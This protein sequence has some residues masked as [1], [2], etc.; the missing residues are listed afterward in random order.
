MLSLSSQGKQVVNYAGLLLAYVTPIFLFCLIL[1]ANSFMRYYHPQ[2]AAFAN[3]FAWV[4]LLM[5][6][7]FASTKLRRRAHSKA[8]P[9][10]RPSLRDPAPSWYAFLACSCL[11]AILLAELVGTYNY[12]ANMKF[13][14]GYNDL[15]SY[16][17]V[18]PSGGSGQAFLDA[19]Q[20][21]FVNTSRLQLSRSMGFYDGTMYCVAP[22]V[23][24]SEP[25]AIYDFW[26]VGVGCCS[27]H[28]ADFH[29][30]PFSDANAHQGLRLLRDDQRPF[31]QLAVQQAESVYQI[32]ANSP[33]F[34]TWTKDAAGNLE[35]YRH[36]SFMFYMFWIFCFIG[37]QTFTTVLALV[38]Y[39]PNLGKV[40]LS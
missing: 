38:L 25:P 28:A 37:L 6:A 8:D 7:Y 21:S 27:G 10:L 34:L 36:D 2:A 35:K 31:F 23:S 16:A 3:V 19:G 5:Q 29:C 32:K 9:L 13:L 20:I 22:I 1:N 40:E 26:A 33:I 39:Y 18:D 14:Y 4:V 15:N 11:V 17:G 12:V 24:T 30:G